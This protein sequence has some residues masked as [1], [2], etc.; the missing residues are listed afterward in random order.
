M[1]VPF[2]I[3]RTLILGEF[4]CSLCGQVLTKVI[5]TRFRNIIRL[6]RLY[7]EHKRPNIFEE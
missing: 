3:V 4:M 5:F 2:P 7:I 6:C 1:A